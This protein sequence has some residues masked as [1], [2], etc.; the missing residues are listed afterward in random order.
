MN[1]NRENNIEEF[2]KSIKKGKKAK[3]EFNS[4][5]ERPKKELLKDM[6]HYQILK[7][8]IIHQGDILYMPEDAKTN[9]KFVLVVVDIYNKRLD[10]EPL[11]SLLT[12]KHEVFT[13]LNT[14]YSR[15]ILN[16]PQLITFDSGNEFKDDN[17]K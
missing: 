9:D 11:K 12:E 15:K 4:L 8:D 3:T 6:P 5:Y 10:A 1:D 2:V 14:I 13:A 17:L 16:H 7:P